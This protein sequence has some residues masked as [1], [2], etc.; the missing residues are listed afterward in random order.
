M[1]CSVEDN[2]NLTDTLG[3]K[4]TKTNIAKVCLYDPNAT[5]KTGTP[6]LA[7]CKTFCNIKE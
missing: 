5:S 3:W 6:N 4:N 2:K 1:V 7:Q